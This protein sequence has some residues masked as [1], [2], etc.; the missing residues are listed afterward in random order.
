MTS[1][2]RLPDLSC[3]CLRCHLEDLDRRGC[4]GSLAGVLAWCRAEPAPTDWVVPWLE[5]RGGFCDCEALMNA[6][7]DVPLFVS[8][9]RLSCYPELEEED[10]WDDE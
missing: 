3:P 6:L 4:D 1:P 2:A 10:D 8:G 5:A 9:L 7:P